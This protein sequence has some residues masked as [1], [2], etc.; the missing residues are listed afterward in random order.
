MTI[1]SSSPRALRSANQQGRMDCETQARWFRFGA[2]RGAHVWE[3]SR[4]RTKREQIAPWIAVQA[5]LA[6]APIHSIR[7]GMRRLARQR[8]LSSSLLAAACFSIVRNAH[9]DDRGSGPRNGTEMG[10]GPW[11]DAIRI[12]VS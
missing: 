5:I 2:A 10:V 4:Q 11:L 12:L 1:R 7:Y 3:V 6:R 9:R 8:L